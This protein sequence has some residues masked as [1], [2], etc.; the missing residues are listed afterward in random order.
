MAHSPYTVAHLFHTVDRMDF[1]V[2]ELPDGNTYMICSDTWDGDTPQLVQLTHFDIDDREDTK[3]YRQVGPE[4]FESRLIMTSADGRHW[5]KLVCLKRSYEH[6]GPEGGYLVVRSS[7]PNTRLN[8]RLVGTTEGHAWSTR[9]P[10][11]HACGPVESYELNGNFL[12]VSRKAGFSVMMHVDW[13][14]DLESAS[15]LVTPSVPAELVN[16]YPELVGAVA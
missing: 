3:P 6:T 9:G 7:E 8:L 12:T 1:V 2:L 14:F 5:T 15:L 10:D 11:M 4:L 16:S 13:V